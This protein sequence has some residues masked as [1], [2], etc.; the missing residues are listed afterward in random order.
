[1]TAPTNYL[2]L[3]DIN[4]FDKFAES[5]AKIQAV[6]HGIFFYKTDEL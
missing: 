5:L 1:M 4:K 3:A 2:W 6:S